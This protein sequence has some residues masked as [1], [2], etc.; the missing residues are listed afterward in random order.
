MVIWYAEGSRYRNGKLQVVPNFS[1]S[2]AA[3][4]PSCIMPT[5]PVRAGAEELALLSRPRT[6]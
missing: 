1:T 4:E 3:Y 6:C 2:D 5:T